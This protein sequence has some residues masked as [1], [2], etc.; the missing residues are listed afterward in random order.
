VTRQA[1]VGQ[2]VVRR[3]NLSHVLRLLHASGPRTRAE[4]TAFTGLN[5]S[6]V[7]ALVADL[8]ARQLVTEGEA[9]ATGTPGRPSP[10]V[11][12]RTDRHVVLALDVGVDSLAAATVALGGHRLAHVRLERPRRRTVVDTTIEDLGTLADEVLGELGR[13]HRLVGI[14]VSVAG[15]VRTDDGFVHVAPNLGWRDVALAELL[16]ARLR[17]RVP[18]AVANDADAGALAER[19]HG[20]GRGVDDLVY[21]S[22]EVGVGGGV[23]VDGR[24][25]RGVGGYAGEIG[26]I[27]VDVDGLPCVCGAVGCWETRVGEAAL[28]R[29]A[30]EPEEGGRDAVDRVLAAAEEGDAVALGALEELGRWMA[31][32]LAAIANVFDPQRIVLGGLHGRVHPY[33]NGQ[34]AEPPR[35]ELLT[36]REPVQ[37]VP[38]VLADS[39]LAGAAELAF[40]AILD[41]PTTVAPQRTGARAA[42]TQEP[43]T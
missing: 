35:S 2:D 18:I 29:L 20:A 30:G 24:P 13:G 8:A 43:V 37:I 6:T 41:D 17:R 7:A 5:R 16:R 1:G 11:S 42:R 32:G 22:G 40:G 26:H 38:A 23:I 12:L 33:L 15:L 9:R 21:I 39:S 4:L 3:V 10:M 25:L 36:V 27:P 28:L 19:V 31:V 14:G 34:V